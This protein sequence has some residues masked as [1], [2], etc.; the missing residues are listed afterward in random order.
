MLPRAEHITPSNAEFQREKLK[1]RY[2][3][4]A[5]G[6]WSFYISSFLLTMA[7]PAAIIARYPAVF[8]SGGEEHRWLAGSYLVLGVMYAIWFVF[9]VCST[10]ACWRRRAVVSPRRFKVWKLL[11]P[12]LTNV[13]QQLQLF[14]ASSGSEE[15]APTNATDQMDKLTRWLSNREKVLAFAELLQRA[16]YYFNLPRDS[17]HDDLNRWV[18]EM[19]VKLKQMH[20]ELAV[21]K[22]QR[23]PFRDVAA[24]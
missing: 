1:L 3:W 20:G 12:A 21:R 17:A 13:V 22:E 5:I 19:A 9:F 14:S 15:A 10:Q 4:M 18:N 2:L 11:G 6:S 7:L 16:A 8:C 23:G 24:T